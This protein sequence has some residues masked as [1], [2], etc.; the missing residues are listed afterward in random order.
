MWQLTLLIQFRNL[1]PQEMNKTFTLTGKSIVILTIFTILPGLF[2]NAGSGH[3]TAKA[4]TFK[5]SNPVLVSGIAG[6]I[7][8]RYFFKNVYNNKDAVITIENIV[9]G[10]V[11]KDMDNTTTGYPDAWQPTVGGPGTFGISYIKWDVEFDSAGVPYT[12]PLLDLS[13]ADVDGDNVRVRE[14]SGIVG[15]NIN[16]DLPDSIVPSLLTIS[17]QKDT[18]NLWGTDDDDSVFMALGPVANR[19]GIDTLA[20]DVRIDYTFTNR[21]SF[22]IY[23]GSQVDNNGKPGGIATDRFHS[24]YFG[25]FVAA[26][27]VLPV[28]LQNFNVVW[29]NDAVNLNWAMGSDVG[30]I[31]FEIERSF[32]QTNFSN[33]GL[34]LGSQSVNNGAFQFAF[35]DKDKEISNHNIVYYRLKQVDNNGSYNYSVVKPVRIGN[36]NNQKIAVQVMPNP[37]MDKLKV[38]I[39]SQTYGKAQIRMI[40]AW[41]RAVKTLA[42]NINKGFNDLQ[43]EDLS[44]QLPGVYVINVVVNGQSIGTL[45][46]IKN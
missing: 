39:E 38:N 36:N 45:K 6:N 41:G 9:G 13:A 34:V 11:L 42:A 43:L 26:Y 31:Y 44:N 16:Y 15:S 25:D 46:I 30:N 21:S 12:F 14:L 10:A 24:I 5:F 8:A 1:K 22:Q 33:T 28:T 35:T 27:S 37:Y 18:D 3:G 19:A 40:S 17:R 7:G 20:L 32:D 29:K 4:P 23:T 2:A